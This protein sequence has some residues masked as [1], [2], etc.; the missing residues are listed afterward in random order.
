MTAYGAELIRTN[1]PLDKRL[2]IK[3]LNRIYAKS[4]DYLNCKECVLWKGYITSNKTEY[5]NFYF[6]GRKIALHRL[7]YINFKGNLR[8]N[9]Y[10]E[11]T[12]DNKGRCSN[13]NHIKKKNKNKPK[14][15]NTTNVVYFD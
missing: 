14:V 3:D 7:L 11:Y 10:L 8:D 13:I 12:C 5:I 1:C 4:G 2:S 9:D 6:N 15:M